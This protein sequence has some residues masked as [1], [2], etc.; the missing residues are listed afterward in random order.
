MVPTAGTE[1]GKPLNERLGRTS[2][3]SNNLRSRRFGKHAGPSIDL[4]VPARCSRIGS[5]FVVSIGGCYLWRAVW[6]DD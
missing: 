6:L 2:A 3:R 4:A 1:A 5:M